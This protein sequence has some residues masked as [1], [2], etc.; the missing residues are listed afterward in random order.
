VSSGCRHVRERTPCGARRTWPD[1]NPAPFG[2]QL[3]GITPTLVFFK[4]L[5]RLCPPQALTGWDTDHPLSRDQ[6]RG[7]ADRRE[8]GDRQR[9]KRGREMRQ[10]REGGEGAKHCY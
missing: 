10:G 5:G 9:D 3:E 1:S 8:R 2:T 7:R 6:T 4:W